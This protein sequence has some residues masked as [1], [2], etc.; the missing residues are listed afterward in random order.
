[1]I[2]GTEDHDTRKGGYHLL[3]SAVAWLQANPSG[4]KVPENAFWQPETCSLIVR[5]TI[6]LMLPH[7][8]LMVP[9]AIPLIDQPI[10][11]FL[12]IDS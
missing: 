1:M 6:D 2:R 3:V 5:L 4:M 11:K 8:L 12:R 10:P 9:L 7:T